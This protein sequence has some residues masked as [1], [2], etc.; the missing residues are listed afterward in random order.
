[1]LIELGVVEQRHKAVL[2]VLAG[3][4]VVE[5]A[6]R[7]GVSRQTLHRWLRRYAR[8]GIGGLAD[9]SPRPARCPHRTPP[10]VEARI[11]SLRLAHPRWGPRTIAHYL[12]KEELEHYPSRSS[13]YRCLVRHHLIDPQKRRRRREDYRRWE[14]SKAM[15]LWQMD[16]MGGVKL[17]GGRELKLVSGI[18]DHSRFCVSAMLVEHATTRPVCEALVAAMR[19]HGIPE[20]ILTDNGKV[21]TGRFGA[22][23]REVLFDRLCRKYGVR[24]L[25][26]AP[27]SPTTTGKVERFHKT[28][29]AELLAG[30]VFASIEQAQA[31]LDAWVA[32]YNT[33][34]P[35]QGIGMV[36]PIKRFELA[37]R[38]QQPVMQQPDADA[39][40]AETESEYVPGEGEVV[41]RRVREGGRI[42]LDGFDYYVGAYLDGESVEVLT[43]SS[44]LVDVRHRG[45][46]LACHA[47]RRPASSPI[48]RLQRSPGEAHRVAGRFVLRTVDAKGA[49]S[50]AAGT[51]AV[52][53]RLSG[54]QVEVRIGRGKVRISKNGELLCTHA[55]HHDRSKELGAFAIPKGRPRQR[56]KTESSDE[57]TVAEELKPMRSTGTET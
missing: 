35:H 44:G 47:R 6:E 4:S 11:V 53:K 18:D 31:E 39:V 38:A 26:T 20:Q 3:S 22:H 9:A 41:T 52:A 34:R 29:R 2:E 24:H 33:E 48:K 56:T 17:E 25:L 15:E 27:Y 40:D 50:F 10:A 14:R 55:I 43:R 12:A 32:F 49:I 54:E 37:A 57:I 21:F 16:V 13:I 45:E 19:R 7:Y 36:A 30:R 23:K 8:S 5:V 46:F 51:Y 1:M 28:L 42:S